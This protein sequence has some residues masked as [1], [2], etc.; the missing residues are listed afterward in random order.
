MQRYKKKRKENRLKYAIYI[1]I[2][3][4]STQL[5]GNEEYLRTIEVLKCSRKYKT[6][7]IKYTTDNGHVCKY[8]QYVCLSKESQSQ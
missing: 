4:C 8:K 3:I 5:K 7:V 2:Y 1:Y 6:A